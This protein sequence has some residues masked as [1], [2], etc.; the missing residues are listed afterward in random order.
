VTDREDIA[1]VIST[2]RVDLVGVGEGNNLRSTVADIRADISHKLVDSLG[3][4]TDG[5]SAALLVGDHTKLLPETI[6]DFRTSGLSHVLAISG[7][8]IAMVGSIIMAFSAW[9]FGH[10]KQ[11]YMLAPFMGVWG[12]AL[13]AGLTP[14]VTRAA[15]MFSVYSAARLL[16]CLVDSA[17]CCLRWR[18]R[19]R[20]C[21]LSTRRLSVRFRSNSV[22]LL[23]WR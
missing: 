4:K 20:S 15:I 17:V 3:S 21:W 12:Y 7:L 23:Y 13:L 16:G 5:L 6:T 8:H 18:W 19:R 9:V 1:G 10:R 11:L 22:L 14:S 2:S